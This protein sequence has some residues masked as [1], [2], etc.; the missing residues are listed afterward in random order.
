VRVIRNT[1]N[2]FCGQNVEV[3]NFYASGTYTYDRYLILTCVTLNSVCY[4]VMHFNETAVSFII[5]SFH[6]SSLC[7]LAILQLCV[8][9]K[10]RETSDIGCDF[11]K[12]F[13]RDQ[14]TW[15]L[16]VQTSLCSP[17]FVSDRAVP[18]TC[19]VV[20]IYKTSFLECVHL[21]RRAVCLL[22]TAFCYCMSDLLVIPLCVYIEARA[23]AFF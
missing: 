17:R 5:L 18:E 8:G 16:W 10:H 20:R 13:S 21:Q 23:F 22:N 6:V 11:T 12:I 4:T 14:G 9:E 7:T 1:V 19:C 2:T 15:F 3:L